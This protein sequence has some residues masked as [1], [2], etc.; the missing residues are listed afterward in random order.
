MWAHSEPFLRDWHVLLLVCYGLLGRRSTFGSCH[1]PS[2]ALLRCASG[3]FV[4][5]VCRTVMHWTEMTKQ[6]TRRP[7]NRHHRPRR[8]RHEAERMI[9]KKIR[10]SR[11][12]KDGRCRGMR[13]WKSRAVGDEE[14][15]ETNRDPLRETV[16]SKHPVNSRNCFFELCEF[17]RTPE[18]KRSISGCKSI[19]FFTCI[20]FLGRF[21][22]PSDGYVGR[23][24]RNSGSFRTMR[25]TRIPIKMG[26]WYI[27]RRRGPGSVPRERP[28]HP[29]SASVG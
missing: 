9:G 12:W 26:I 8:G 20:P 10:Q 21:G 1:A 15:R 28:P 16:L 23:Y 13:R 25:N 18:R 2:F 17:L 22:S 27:D 5:C 4:S 11:G 6:Y 24:P 3:V 14:G 29:N 19:L 7:T